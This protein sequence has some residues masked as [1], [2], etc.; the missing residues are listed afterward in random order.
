MREFPPSAGTRK[1]GTRWRQFRP[2]GRKKVLVIVSLENI[3]AYWPIGGLKMPLRTSQIFDPV[4][5]V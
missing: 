4:V 2:V 3:H 5:T 1:H